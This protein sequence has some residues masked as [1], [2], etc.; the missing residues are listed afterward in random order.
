MGRGL[1]SEEVINQIRD[2]IDI[3]DLVGQHVS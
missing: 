1:I 3:V 2:R